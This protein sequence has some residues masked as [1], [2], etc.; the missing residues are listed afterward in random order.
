[1][2]EQSIGAFQSL[3]PMIKR[4]R[5]EILNYFESMR[6]L[7]SAYGCYRYAA[8]QTEPVLY[9]SPCAASPSDEAFG[10]KRFLAMLDDGRSAPLDVL[11]GQIMNA[12]AVCR[13]PRPQNDDT[14]MLTVEL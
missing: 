3:L 11:P 14:T 7:N 4:R 8:C 1:M 5:Q 9:A 10:S 6:L 13:G 12:L 2:R